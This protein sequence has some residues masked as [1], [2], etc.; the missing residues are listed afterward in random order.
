M[1]LALA[2]AEHLHRCLVSVQNFLPVQFRAQRVDQRLTQ[3]YPANAN[4]FTCSQ[5]A[6]GRS[7]S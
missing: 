1:G 4:P 2:R 6:V 3:S 7:Q 5:F